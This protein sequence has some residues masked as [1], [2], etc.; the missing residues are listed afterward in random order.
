MSADVIVIGAISFELPV[1]VDRIPEERMIQVFAP[2]RPDQSLDER[3]RCR[4]VRHR[5]DLLDLEDSQVREP[6]MKAAQ[7]IVIRTDPN[8]RCLAGD[9]L[10]EHAAYGHP[11]DAFPA[12]A[13]SDDAAGK[14]IDDNQ[15]SMTAKEDRFA[16]KQVHTPETVRGL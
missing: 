12:D 2:D 9:G 1:K 6:S 7:G 15:D 10:I 13:E 3:V 16:P 4:N 5:F 11:V 8:W 14:H